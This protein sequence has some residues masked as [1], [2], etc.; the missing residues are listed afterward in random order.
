MFTN[1]ADNNIILKKSPFVF[2]KAL[3]FIQ[4][5]FGLTPIM[6]SILLDF[7][8]QYNATAFAQTISYN[9]LVVIISTTLQVLIIAVSFLIWYVPTYLITPEHILLKRGNI[10]PDIEIAQLTKIEDIGVKQRWLGK[11]VGY[12]TLQLGNGREVKNVSDPHRVSRM[13]NEMET[14][15]PTAPPF[16]KTK[17]T[18]QL[19]AEGENQNVEFKSSLLWDYHQQIPNKSLYV[20]IMKNAAALM[21]TQGGIIII[22][23]ADDGHI[24]G[25]EPDFNIMKKKNEDGF[26]NTFNLAFNQMIGAEFRQ[27]LEFEFEKIEEKTIG[28][29][30]VQPAHSPVFLT[31]NGKETFHIKTGNSSQPLTI[32]QA[33]QYIQTHF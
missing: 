16:I 21:N 19:I 28:I 29:A 1:D 2:L 6:L 25:L 30:I 31:H 26:E 3:V 9:L 20:P 17:T 7:S 8:E 22:G 12:G 14:A 15:V 32:S 23:V 11:R 5:A 18:S 33:T 27:Y 13:I 4:F 24:L 10:F